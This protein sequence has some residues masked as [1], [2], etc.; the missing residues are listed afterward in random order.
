MDNPSRREMG[1]ERNLLACR[2]DGSEFPIE[3]GLG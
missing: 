2:K 3:V 1:Y